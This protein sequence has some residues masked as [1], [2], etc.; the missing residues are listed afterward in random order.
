M[1]L[2]LP[3]LP[4]FQP[5]WSTFQTWWQQVKE[6][7][8]RNEEA[9]QIL[10]DAIDEILGEQGTGVVGQLAILGS[11]SIPTLTLTAADVGASVTITV[12]SHIRRY[13]DAT[14]V[15][16]TG[17]T[18][19]GLAYSTVY[20]V[21]YDDATRTLATPTFVATT[22]LETGQHNYAEGR[23]YLGTVTTPAAAGPPTTGGSPP[24]GS[25]YTAGAGAM[26]IT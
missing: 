6:A 4:E 8:E 11:Y 21:Y 3:P 22:D 23:H 13:A 2:Q 15:A 14:E 1:A 25:G 26:N 7:I 24:A 9:Q 19:T 12:A 10:F 16:V 17:G 5:T 20:A 18:V